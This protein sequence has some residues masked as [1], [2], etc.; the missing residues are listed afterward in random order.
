MKRKISLYIGGKLADLST[1]ALVQM[2]YTAEDLSDPAI[3]KNSY[4][5]QITLPATRNN[6]AIFGGIFRADRRTLSGNGIGTSFSPLVRTPFA[7]YDEAGELLESGYIKLDSITA[8]GVSP[9]YVITLYGGLGSFFYTL[10]Y[11]DEGN[12]MTLGNLPLLDNAEEQ[13]EFTINKETV[14]AAWAALR[15]GTAGQWQAVNFAPAY[16]GFPDGGFSADKAV[17]NPIDVGGTEVTYVGDKTYRPISKNAL[18]DL[19]ED[20]TEWQTKDL[21][22]YLQRPAVSVKSLIAGISRFAAARGFALDLDPAFFSAANPYYAD[23]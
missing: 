1:D 18:F 10:S 21:R 19:G 6:D 15:A 2:N 9:A 7:I 8:K 11:D 13:I 4:S 5:Q 3:V 17:G 23:A 16:N 12:E 22:S 14:G 20:F